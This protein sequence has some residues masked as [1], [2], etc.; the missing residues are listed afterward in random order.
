M[1][2]VAHPR[3]LAHNECL[4]SL[5]E[6]GLNK[7]CM[8]QSQVAARFTDHQLSALC[9]ELS[10]LCVV[11]V[12]VC[13]CM[14]ER[15]RERE[16]ERE[17]QRQRETET[18]TESERQKERERERER[19]RAN[20]AA[21]EWSEQTYSNQFIGAHLHRNCVPP[22][23]S[24]QRNG[25]SRRRALTVH[26]RHPCLPRALSLQCSASAILLHVEDDVTVPPPARPRHH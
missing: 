17:R 7:A 4:S 5:C 16:R 22:H 9:V 21:D 11:C 15:G 2:L 10:A 8:S 13:V 25:P 23:H 12:C 1:H 3:L 6:H 18:E 26:W 20:V 19:E 14:R 24:R